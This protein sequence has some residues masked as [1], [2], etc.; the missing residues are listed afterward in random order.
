MPGKCKRLRSHK[1]I[2]KPSFNSPYRSDRRD[3]SRPTPARYKF[4]HVRRNELFVASFSFS[5]PF[6]FFYFLFLFFFRF[7]FHFCGTVMAWINTM[8]G[9]FRL[10]GFSRR[11]FRRTR[12]LV[13]S[14]AAGTSTVCEGGRRDGRVEGG[15]GRERDEERAKCMCSKRAETSL[16]TV[17]SRLRHHRA[18]TLALKPTHGLLFFSPYRAP[19]SPFG[20]RAAGDG[21]IGAR[22]TRPCPICVY[23]HTRRRATCATWE[24]G[25]RNEP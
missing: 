11:Y 1:C 3:T 24:M 16:Q 25:K 5:F 8:T 20:A 21:E 12:E 22:R 18:T 2:C 9:C 17:R 4:K 10:S 14:L 23:V 6:S 19:L 15:K 7:I 13:N